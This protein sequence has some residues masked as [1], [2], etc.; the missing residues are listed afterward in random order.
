MEKNE[1]IPPEETPQIDI[2]KVKL[3]R[4]WV[5]WENYEAKNGVISDYEKS[6][7]E[8]FK[9]SDIISFWQFWNSYPGSDP[10]DIFYNGERLRLYYL[11]FI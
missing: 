9:F 1:I 10:S 3:E 4:S 11:F 5:L 8:V 7:Q 6:I 2:E